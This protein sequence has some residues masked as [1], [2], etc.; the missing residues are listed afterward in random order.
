LIRTC[1]NQPVRAIW[2]RPS[3]SC[4]S[5]FANPRRQHALGVAGAHA[6]RRNPALDEP[7][8]E[9]RRQRAGLQHHPHQSRRT[10]LERAA[11]RVRV[12][13]AGPRPHDRP[14]YVRHTDVRRLVRD[15]QR[16]VSS[17]MVHP[18]P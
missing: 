13:G 2:A 11:D 18:P 10:G 9:E 3:A 8:V 14:R 17:T 12:G 7:V 5:L 1:L 15:I 6:D 16:G 4:G